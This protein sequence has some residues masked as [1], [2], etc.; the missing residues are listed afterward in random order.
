MYI[1]GGS[2]GTVETCTCIGIKRKEK[3]GRGREQESRL[4][5]PRS[6]PLP[7]HTATPQQR[8]TAAFSSTHDGPTRT[9][10][11]AGAQIP[12]RHGDHDRWC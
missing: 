8:N 9:S 7:H 1:I 6:C 3:E 12:E 10:A 2:N 11:G 5:P 4:S